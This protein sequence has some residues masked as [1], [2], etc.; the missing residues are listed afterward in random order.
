MTN[1]D[2]LSIAL[3]AFR[4]QRAI[5]GNTI[6]DAALADIVAACHGASASQILDALKA[7]EVSQ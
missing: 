6:S 1:T 5:R 7:E 2:T 4:F 3:E